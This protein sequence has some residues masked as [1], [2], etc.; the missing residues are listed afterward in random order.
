MKTKTQ[1]GS[2]GPN[3]RHNKLVAFD[4]ITY[5]QIMAAS[6]ALGIPE[7]AFIRLA[8]HRALE[9]ILP[10][11]REFVDGLARQY[12]ADQANSFGKKRRSSKVGSAAWQHQ[13]NN[14]DVSDREAARAVDLAGR[15]HT[16]RSWGELNFPSPFLDQNYARMLL[17]GNL[18][19]RA[20]RKAVTDCMAEFFRERVKVYAENW[21]ALGLLQKQVTKVV[22]EN[23][24]VPSEIETSNAK[25]LA[26]LDAIRRAVS[27][28]R[29][30]ATKYIKSLEESSPLVHQQWKMA[31][32]EERLALLKQKM[33]QI[34]DRQSS[35]KQIRHRRLLEFKALQQ[36]PS[37]WSDPVEL[38]KLLNQ[39]Q[40]KQGIL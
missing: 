23:P 4:G 24:S 22:F 39:Y 15:R 18:A 10:I 6:I 28:G 29:E 35:W 1:A 2:R 27:A 17:G 3:L 14:L 9:Q 31:S 32:A 30:P 11:Y 16:P 37:V 19:N 26:Q 21:L 13:L 25:H 33:R 7:T 12:V 38:Q 34:D 36:N 8:V 5:D 40:N 20:A